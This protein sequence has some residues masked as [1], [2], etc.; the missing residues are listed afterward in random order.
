MLVLDPILVVFWRKAL[1]VPFNPND[2][3]ITN[4]GS[5]ILTTVY[6]HPSNFREEADPIILL[7]C[8]WK[9]ERRVSEMVLLNHLIVQS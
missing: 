9:G 4:Y 2:P 5:Q 3:D 7:L 6:N 8:S 1:T